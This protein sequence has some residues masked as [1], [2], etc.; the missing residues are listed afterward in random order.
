MVWR[1]GKDREVLDCMV[2][3]GFL[4]LSLVFEEVLVLFLGLRGDLIGWVELGWRWDK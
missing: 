2:F 3:F 1:L 4:V